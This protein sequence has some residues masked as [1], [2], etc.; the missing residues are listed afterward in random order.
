MITQEKLK[1]L[2]S[3][4]ENTGLFTRIVKTNRNITIGEIAGNNCRGR[5]VI[6][7]EGKLYRAH[8]LVWLYVYGKFP[9]LLIDHINGD[10]TDNRLSNLR[11]VTAQINSQ[12]RRNAQSNNKL[13]VLGVFL[14]QKKYRAAIV[15]NRKQIIIGDFENIEFAKNAYLIAKRKLHHGCTI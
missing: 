9:T 10:A 14:Y 8:R 5:I 7:I 15:I 12:N 1:Q 11:E 13:G 3:Y 2:F 6:S 4:D